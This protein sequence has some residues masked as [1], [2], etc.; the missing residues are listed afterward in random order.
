MDVGEQTGDS[1][2]VD[3]QV[4]EPSEV[5]EEITPDPRNNKRRGKGNSDKK[6]KKRKEMKKS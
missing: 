2:G 1:S 3:E 4:S 5:V 6:L